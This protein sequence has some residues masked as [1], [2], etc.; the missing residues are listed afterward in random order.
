MWTFKC[1]GNKYGTIK[2]LVIFILFFVA[3]CCR[4]LTDCEANQFQHIIFIP[5]CDLYLTSGGL[6]RSR[7]L[8]LHYCCIIYLHSNHVLCVSASHCQHFCSNKYNT[9]L[10]QVHLLKYKYGVLLISGGSGSKMLTSQPHLHTNTNKKHV[11]LEGDA[12]CHPL[13]Q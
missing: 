4:K 12:Q 9:Y 6:D 7:T 5:Q 1:V 8:W 13:G 3:F 2:T 11:N 10:S